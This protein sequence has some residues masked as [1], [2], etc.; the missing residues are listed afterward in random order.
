MYVAINPQNKYQGRERK[1]KKGLPQQKSDAFRNISTRSR[2]G[3]IPTQWLH[4]HDRRRSVLQGARSNHHPS[5]YLS[6]MAHPTPP[7]PPVFQVRRLP[8]I[9]V[10]CRSRLGHQISNNYSSYSLTMLVDNDISDSLPPLLL[11]LLLLFSSYQSPLISTD[12]LN[13]CAVV[14]ALESL[15]L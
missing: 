14:L 7:V 3:V 10:V 1:K 5:E 8:G 6:A 13:R 4:R 2:S 9:A 15:F 12:V 11:H